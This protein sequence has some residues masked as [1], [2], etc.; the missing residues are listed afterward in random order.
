MI[1]FLADVRVKVNRK[2]LLYKRSGGERDLGAEAKRDSSHP[3]ADAFAGAKAEEKIGLP[4]R[5]RKIIRDA[6]DANEGGA[7]LRESRGLILRLRSGR[8]TA[9]AG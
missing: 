1:L 3:Q 5:S 9:A 8:E 2:I 7:F 6:N 4:V